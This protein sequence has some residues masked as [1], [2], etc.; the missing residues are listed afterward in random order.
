MFNGQ[1]VPTLVF[2]KG[3]TVAKVSLLRTDKVDLRGFDPSYSPNIHVLS[4]PGG[5][6]YIALVVIEGGKQ[7]Y[8]D[9]LKPGTS[10]R[11]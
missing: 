3:D 5:G 2:R 6:R 7:K 9:F 11:T 4:D 1:S 10:P 8:S